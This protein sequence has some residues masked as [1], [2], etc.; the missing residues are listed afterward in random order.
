VSLL[1]SKANSFC[2]AKVGTYRPSTTRVTLEIELWASG[3]DMMENGE[4]A[5]IDFQLSIFQLSHI[6]AEAP[7]VAGDD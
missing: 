7:N 2:Q 1:R 6:D 4:V 3:E 5:P